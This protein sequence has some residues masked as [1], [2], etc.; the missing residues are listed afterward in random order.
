MKLIN[1][2]GIVSSRLADERPTL[3]EVPFERRGPALGLIPDTQ[4]PVETIAL[5][6]R[7][8]LMLYTDGLVEGR[9]RDT[10]DRLGTDGLLQLLVPLVEGDDPLVTAQTLIAEAELLHGGALPDD[11]ALLLLS[12]DA[13]N[14]A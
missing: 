12:H 10:P 11:V 9:V 2:M 3:C 7:W 1:G 14:N 8:S 6:E 13:T 5:P 4:W